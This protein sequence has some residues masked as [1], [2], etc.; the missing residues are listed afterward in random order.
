MQPLITFKQLEAVYWIVRL[1]GFSQ[2]AGKLH[3]SQSAISKRV[4]ELEALFG[5]ALFDR[6]ARS[7]RLT[8][9]GQEMFAIAK[10]LLDERDSAVEQFLSPEGVERSVRIGVTELTAMTWLPKLVNLIEGRYPRV[11]IEP[12]VDNSKSLREKLAADKLDLMVV[13]GS[14]NDARL[15]SRP[16]GTVKNAWMCKPGLVPARKAVRIQELAAHRLLTQSERS[17]TGSIYAQW[18]EALDVAP[19]EKII[20]NN[21][22]AIIGMTV[23]GLGVSHLPR[24]CLQPMIRDGSLAVIKTIPELP[25]IPYI[26]A[27]KTGRRSALVS[28]IVAFAEEACDFGTL[29]QTA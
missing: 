8:E 2:A 24:K 25:D 19:S 28:S 7:S 12:D 16:I 15:S 21:L 13:P 4:R 6:A 26:V 27:H 17:G 29:Y 10:R 20:S 22:V 23:S 1:G 3:T 5:T 11:T 9:K 18:L 14:A